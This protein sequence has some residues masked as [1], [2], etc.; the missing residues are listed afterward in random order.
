MFVSNVVSSLVL[1]HSGNPISEKNALG[2]PF[3][4]TFH[5]FGFPDQGT[6]PCP[7]ISKTTSLV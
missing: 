2:I 7:Q 5:A 6:S 4:T 1:L 3:I